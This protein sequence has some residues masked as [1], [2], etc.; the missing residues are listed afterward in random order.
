MNNC[1]PTYY[2]YTE[3]N[4]LLN[5]PIQYFQVLVIQLWIVEYHK[6]ISGRLDVEKL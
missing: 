1:K 5:I 4:G 3:K 6:L 2:L